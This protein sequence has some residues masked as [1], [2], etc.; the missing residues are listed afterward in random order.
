MFTKVKVS[1]AHENHNIAHSR[2]LWKGPGTQKG[3]SYSA[4]PPEGRAGSW[5]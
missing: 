4:P 5:I 3:R 1:R 2:T